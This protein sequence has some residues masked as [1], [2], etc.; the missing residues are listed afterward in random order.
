[1][2]RKFH[3]TKNGYYSEPVDGLYKPLHK[4]LRDNFL[5]GIA[6]SLGATLGIAIVVGLTT[7]LL[8]QFVNFPI[9]GSFI[10]DIVEATNQALQKR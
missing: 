1:M 3:T 10:A 4:L 9:V 8:G 6:W 5:G 2:V 7:Y